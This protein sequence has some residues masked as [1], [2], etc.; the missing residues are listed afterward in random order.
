MQDIV[1]NLI[2]SAFI[3]GII[4]GVFVTLLFKCI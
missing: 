2:V 1:T 4:V 3:L